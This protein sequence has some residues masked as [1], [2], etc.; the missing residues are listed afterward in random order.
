[1]LWFKF[2]N[3]H[4]GSTC[5]IDLSKFDIATLDDGKI[6]LYPNTYSTPD[7]FTIEG[8]DAKR[9]IRLLDREARMVEPAEF[10][11]ELL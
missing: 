4:S 3:R 11:E 5:Y 7:R 6:E 8:D 1:M 9:L 10:G 2:H